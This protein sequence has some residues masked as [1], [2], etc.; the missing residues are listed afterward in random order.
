MSWVN[1]IDGVYGKNDPV[2]DDGYAIKIPLDP[3]IKVHT[4][5]LNAIIDEVYIIIPKN[6]PPFFMIF[7]NK[8]KLTCFPLH[9]DIDKL[10]KILDLNLKGK[11]G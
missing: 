1:G 6:N 9:E 5:L 7:E 4:K 8:D 3:A 10:S 2:K 11:L